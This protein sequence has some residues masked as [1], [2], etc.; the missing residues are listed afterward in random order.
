MMPNRSNKRVPNLKEP[1][2]RYGGFANHSKPL[3]AVL[4][5]ALSTRFPLYKTPFTTTDCP[6]MHLSF[7]HSRH[8]HAME[9]SPTA[10]GSR[11]ARHETGSPG[12]K[13]RPVSR[14]LRRHLLRFA[15]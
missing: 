8:L 14:P 10:S 3:T 11:K 12:T 1:K 2:T 9:A 5:S 6:P 7:R 4:N 15:V 13:W